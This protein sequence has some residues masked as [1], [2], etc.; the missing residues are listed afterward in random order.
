[1]HACFIVGRWSVKQSVRYVYNYVPHS[2][3]LYMGN[4]CIGGAFEVSTTGIQVHL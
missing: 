4:M 1:M 2:C 3:P